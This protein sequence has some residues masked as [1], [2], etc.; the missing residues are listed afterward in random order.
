MSFWFAFPLW[1]EML[2][3]SSCAYWSSVL[4]PLRIVC[5]VHV[6]I[7]SVGCWLFEKFIFWGPCKFW[8]LIP[9]QMYSWQKFFSSLHRHLFSLVTV[10]F[11]VQ[12]LFSF[13]HSH[14]SICS[15]NCWAIGVQVI[16][17]LLIPYDSVFPI[18]SWSN[19]TVSDLSLRYLIHFELMLI[20]GERLGSSFIFCRWISSFPCTICWKGY[21]LSNVYFGSR[22]WKSNV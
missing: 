20:Q 2:N 22:C 21:L 14:L 9:C 11:A 17:S 8:L 5:S 15:L 12:K 13:M 1:P 4:L 16:K 6:S 10:S 7:Y 19:F 18:F 3:I